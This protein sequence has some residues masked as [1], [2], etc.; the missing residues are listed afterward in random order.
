MSSILGS[1]YKRLR[2][3]KSDRS[4]KYRRLIIIVGLTLALST[5]SIGPLILG[6]A[7]VHGA[8]PR[9]CSTN[10]IN[11]KPLNGGCGSASPE[12]FIA[13]VRA[14]DPSDLQTIYADARLG[15]LT[16]DK[17]DRFAKTAKMGTAYKNGN[18]VVDGQTVMTDMRSIG[19]ETFPG[20]EATI[21]IAGK[22]YYHSRNIDSFQQSSLPAIVMFDK[23]GEVEFAVIASCGNA[24]M[25][26]KVKKEKKKEIEKKEE[27]KEVIEKKEIII[28][29]VEKKVPVEEKKP[30]EL[31]KA[32]PTGLAGIFAGSSAAGAVVHS[33]L[34]SRRRR[35]K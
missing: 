21:V 20:Q 8:I 11:N 29:E 25:G 4:N 23:N 14:N 15:S 27:K 13:D 12:E 28:K 19:R 1:I 17:Y 32:G 6:G 26:K 34:V 33:L 30:P 35:K 2:R 7:T 24:I 18:L 22:T 3:L 16:A 5:A 10:S 9:D 31:P